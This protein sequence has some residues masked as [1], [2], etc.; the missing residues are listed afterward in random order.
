MASP[1]EVFF[2]YAHEDEMW[3]IELEKHLSLLQ[4]KGFITVW[5]D[6]KIASGTAWAQEID[7][8]LKAAHLI[9]L[10]ISSDF[11]ASDY[12]WGVELQEALRR[13][14]RGEACVIPIL[15]RPVDWNEAPFSHLQALPRDNKAIS[16]WSNRDEALTQVAQG[17]RQALVEWDIHRTVT[18]TSSLPFLN[19]PF[20]R[21]PLFTGRERVLEQ[22]HQTLQASKATALTQRQAISG[23]GGIG[24][25]QTA[26]EYAYR[27]Q[28][29]YQ[30]II[31]VKADSQEILTTEFNTLAHLL[32]LPI[33][34][35]QD[36]SFIIDSVKRWFQDHPGWLLVFDNADD[37][38]LAQKYLP[39]GEQGH[40][41]LTTRSQITGTMPSL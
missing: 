39:I 36:Q 32:H 10:L 34:Q 5:H 25:T 24:K 30:L 16:S 23:L 20:E 17:I 9:L 27:H 38:L 19:M 4:H 12:C 7:T 28:S 29:D 13:H 18:F 8:H 11:L 6:R 26:V 2:S 14:Q 3:R 40:I 15:V 33:T 31:W 1:V 21:N 41:L 35:E 22:L 37:L